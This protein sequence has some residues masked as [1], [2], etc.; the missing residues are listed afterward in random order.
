VKLKRPS[1]GEAI[2]AAEIILAAISCAGVLAL[3]LSTGS[4]AR[5]SGRTCDD[6]I[7]RLPT[8]AVATASASY[9]VSLRAA[10]A[11]EHQATYAFW[12]LL[13]IAVT[14]VPTAV[15]AVYAAR[16]TALSRSGLHQEHRPWLF[17][18]SIVIT[19]DLQITAD[20]ARLSFELVTRNV[21][22][23]P[24][25]GV[26]L[27]PKLHIDFRV[28]AGQA[29]RESARLYDERPLE[30]GQTVFPNQPHTFRH[31]IGVGKAEWEQLFKE[32]DEAFP[33]TP[34]IEIFRLAL[35]GT[36]TYGGVLDVRRYHTGFAFDVFRTPFIDS[37]GNQSVAF[38]PKLGSV[39]QADLHLQL[40]WSDTLID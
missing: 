35:I 20:E 30:M 5:A 9:C 21:G 24:A 1:F 2:C 4:G 34:G 29:Q 37:A 26:S 22:R 25:R 32:L 38:G 36:L 18:E 8:D 33:G 15:A 27:S 17:V 39:P 6:L 12:G 14:L 28:P 7:D 13:L 19:S 11:A 31:S 16:Q 3:S 23:T 10:E 40:P